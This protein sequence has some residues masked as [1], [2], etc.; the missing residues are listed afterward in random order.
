M[1]LLQIYDQKQTFAP[2]ILDISTEQLLRT[3]TSTIYT[4]T[5]ISLA[6]TYPT[7]PSIMHS[8]IN[9]YKKLLAITVQTDY[10]WEEISGLK[11]RVAN[12]D[13]YLV[14]VEEKATTA[15]INSAPVEAHDVEA[16]SED[17]DMGFGL[18]D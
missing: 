3:L 7:L 9:G 5:A 14:S 8:L 10:A 16:E 1:R 18:F 15:P 11:D 12:P 17:E 4:V 13:K 6:L 2:A